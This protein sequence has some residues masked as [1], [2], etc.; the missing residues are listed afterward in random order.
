MLRNKLPSYIIIL[1]IALLGLLLAQFLWI[2]RS[3]KLQ[4]EEFNNDIS[5]IAKST[6]TEI[7]KSYYCVDLY[8]NSNLQAGDSVFM[9]INRDSSI[10]DTSELFLWNKYKSDSTSGYKG[11]RFPVP[12]ILQTE[13]HIQYIFDESHASI[14]EI[15]NVNTIKSY[16]NPI[17]A[18]N[19]FIK[20]FDSLFT[21][22]L[23]E[24]NLDT[25]YE[26]AFTD[27]ADSIVFQFPQ[28]LDNSIFESELV[29]PVF[30]DNYF[31]DPYKLYLFFPDK[32]SFILSNLWFM[33]LISF[34][35]VVTS[36][37]FLL[38]SIRTLLNQKRL[39]EM[40]SDFINNMSH[41]FRTPTSNI[42]LAL[43]AIE[44]KR[45]IRGEEI[46]TEE[47][48]IMN[49]IREENNR[50]QDNVEILL[51]TSIMDHKKINLNKELINIHELI[52][53][54]MKTFEQD[55]INNTGVIKS[56][57]KAEKYIVDIDESHFANTI[58]NLIDNGIK[59]SKDSPEIEVI[60]YNKNNNIHLQVKDRGIGI[61]ESSKQRIFE[62]FY[63]VPTGS[64]HNVKG[65]GLG[66]T[67][68]KHVVDSHEANIHLTSELDKGSCFEIILPAISDETE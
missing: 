29:F 54:I 34:I 58:Y 35:F 3:Y 28:D 51:N 30:N 44:I 15:N 8:S 52:E 43:D 24:N 47:S 22:S 40:K 55:F 65:F 11:L 13:I 14:D 64:V 67:Y 25:K 60:T 63:R 42:N 53:R 6:L 59:Y 1:S 33:I 32:G 26:Y 2:S 50:L 21:K 66:L 37:I 62:K 41:E 4:T 12:A 68:V 27:I 57:L 23:I 20:T 45:N 49:I 46:N 10:V 38:I 61:S 31:F 48:A 39:S 9:I 19:E 36:I 16:R 56:N 18:Y 17:S 5:E 7:E